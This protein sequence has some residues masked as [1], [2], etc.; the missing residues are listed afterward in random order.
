MR[1]LNFK[2]KPLVCAVAMATP[3]F[4]PFALAQDG[5]MLEEV[6]VTASYRESLA[7]A[8]DQKRDAVGSRDVILAEDIADFP[9]LNLAESLQ[10]I[11][12]VAIS[13]DAGEGRN[14]SVRGLGPQF[15]R[16]RI[17]GMEAMS[18][19]GGTD[20]SGGA[21]RSRAF[22]FNT[23]ASELFSS[24]AVNKTSS[25]DLDEGSLGAVI[26]LSTAKPLDY[27]DSLT[28]AVSGQLGYNDLAE[29][30]DP[31]GSILVAGKNDADTFGWGATY[32]YSKRNILEE[33]FSAVRWSS[34]RDF[35]SCSG[36]ADQAEFD[37]VNGG[38]YPRIPRYGKLTH[39]QE[40]TGFT[41]TLQWR[42]TDST[43]FS[44]DYLGSEFDATRDEEFVEVSIKESGN[45]NEMDVLDYA[46]DANNT[47]TYMQLDN[48]DTRIEHRFDKLNT[49]FQQLSLTAS[50]EFND[51]LRIDGLIGRSESKFENPVQ[52]TIIFDAV[53][54]SGPFTYDARSDSEFLDLDW[55]TFDLT[56]GDNF[57]FTE[58]RDRPN[59]TDNSFEN[60]S[61]NLEYDLTDTWSVKGGVSVKEYTFD[62][63]E[64]R[65]DTKLSAI[66]GNQPVDGLFSL[67]SLAEGSNIIWLT[68][69]VSKAAA[70][71]DLYN[72]PAQLRD[73]D[74]RSVEETDTGFYVQ[75]SWDSEIS[76]MPLRG[77]IGVRQ[78][79]TD[80]TSTG[81]TKVG[82]DL[83]EVEVN[84]EYTD[85][86][87]SLNAV[88]AVTEDI[89]LRFSYAKVMARP[90]LGNLTPGGSVDQFNGNVKFGNP[91]LDPFR[92]DTFDLGVEWYF[93]D[94]ALISLA[95][96]RKKIDSF[97]ISTTEAGQTWDSTGLPVSIL[98]PSLNF[99]EDDLWTVSKKANGNGG[100]LNGFEMIWQQPIGDSFGVITNYTFVDSE[101]EY[102]TDGNGDIIKNDLL[103]LS[104]NTY[105]IT[106]Y[107]ETDKMG[108]RISYSYRDD[109]LTA[110]PSGSA[111]ND[112]EGTKGTANIDLAAHYNLSDNL[113]LTFEAIN[114][115]DEYNSQFV[116]SSERSSVY[117]H[118]GRQYY[119]GAAYSF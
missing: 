20:S 26:D 94:D 6:V 51:K 40:R 57:M 58:V 27:K 44:L 12:G 101:V 99:T 62:V 37:T 69:D 100:D 18:T 98:D 50:H 56:D 11:P 43:E 54:Q 102:G 65:R 25:A 72:L 116:D 117:H 49:K 15:T 35:A 14:V 115:T 93:A 48:V 59:Q 92:A 110:V 63:T 109:Y 113:K 76:G 13:R 68:P 84:R 7:R 24:M 10:R 83:V 71:V 16:V 95:L 74:D 104:R 118:T 33:G 108:A 79:T 112:L 107:F 114:L 5:E 119:L 87:P 17:N 82:S 39:E 19:T 52:T 29:E 53:N 23:F 88:L 45:A 73:Q 47:L 81:Y 75:A 1:V 70:A 41:G 66:G 31:R 4:A 2:L 85:T 32:S 34:E 36:C 90:D 89:N 55:G 22:D 3:A 97:I 46:I 105:N 77:N 42:P 96:F 38:I 111:G 86:L 91:D 64:A 103:G 8:L 80:V 30:T 60:V 67:T 21:N 61:I 106:G 28:V 78:V 9:D